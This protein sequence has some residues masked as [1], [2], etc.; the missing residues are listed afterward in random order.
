MIGVTTR[1]AH[2]KMAAHCIKHFWIKTICNTIWISHDYYSL[3]IVIVISGAGMLAHIRIAKITAPVNLPSNKNK[4]HLNI[5]RNK[6]NFG[7]FR[8]AYLDG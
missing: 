7:C 3:L 6:Y 2:G 4:I 8:N 5:K 1:I